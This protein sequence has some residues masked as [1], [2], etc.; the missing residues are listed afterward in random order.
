MSCAALAATTLLWM[1]ATP[2]PAQPNAPTPAPATALEPLFADIVA[3]AQNLKAQ[4]EAMRE[5][6]APASE[7]FKTGVADLAALDSR[8]QQ[9]VRDRGVDGDLA[10]ILRGISEDLPVKLAA[11]QMAADKPARD[12]A[13]R[14][15]VYLLNDNIE[16]L[17]APPGPASGLAP[18]GSV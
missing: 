6:D 2:A 5:T 12:T 18:D 4:A 10:C 15:L 3:R 8:G 7:A 14:E 13:L 17:L 1:A 16:V 9:I 11:L